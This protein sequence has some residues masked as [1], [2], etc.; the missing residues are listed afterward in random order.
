MTRPRC[1]VVIAACLI[2]ATLT[3]AGAP[4][5]AAADTA[6]YL[7]G[8]TGGMPAD[9]ERQVTALGGSIVLAVPDGG[10][11]AVSGLTEAAAARLAAS[12]GVKSVE[13]DVVIGPGNDAAETGAGAPV[14]ASI[15]STTSPSAAAF[16]PRQWNLRAIGA[17][18]AWADGQVGAA[19]VRVAIL[20]TGIDYLHPD[21]QGRVDLDPVTGSTSLLP[22][23]DGC[24]SSEPGQPA[25]RPPGQTEDDWARAA[26]REPITDYHSHGTAIAG[27]VA[28]NGHYLAGM[29]QATTLVGIKVHDRG[30]RNCL[31]VYLQGIYEAIER[32][33]DVIHLSFPLEFYKGPD[34]EA[35]EEPFPGAVALVNRAVNHA[36]ANGAVLVAASGNAAEDLDHDRTRFRFCNAVHVICLSATGPTSAT[37]VNGPW[38]AVDTIAEYSN[39]G[40]SAIDVAGP[41]GSG[42]PQGGGVVTPTVPVWLICS[43]VAVARPEGRPCTTGRPGDPNGPV[44]WSSVGTSFAAGA[45]SGLAALVVSILGTDRPA[46]VV[47]VIRESARDLG[48]PGTDPFY[49]RGRIDVAAAVALAMAME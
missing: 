38:E 13:P 2:A 48:P 43:K 8:F 37:T 44:I 4:S 46:D 40:R 20:D 5:A 19:S 23:S 45:T 31:S 9:F 29:T 15:A 18:E 41:G 42:V 7:V 28:S 6:R 24:A 32:D 33:A 17:E 16:Y 47:A 30:R 27:L 22:L 25:S 12:R 26:A 14:E 21:L 11:A 35:D 1:N 34:Q 10:F 36:Y 39:Y 3:P 49:G